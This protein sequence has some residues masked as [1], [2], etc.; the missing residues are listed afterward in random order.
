MW[1]WIKLFIRKYTDQRY[2]T[3]L[4]LINQ[5]RIIYQ[6]ND[7]NGKLI[8]RFWHCLLAYK[9][10]NTYAM[11]LTTY[12]SGKSKANIEMHRKITNSLL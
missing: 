12:F 7:L 8:R 11:V 2:P 10:G 3:M 9:Q 1:C 6:Q 5:S 4:N